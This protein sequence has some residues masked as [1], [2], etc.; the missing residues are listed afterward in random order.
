MVV[1]VNLV[2]DFVLE[3]VHVLELC[4]AV[5]QGVAVPVMT[6]FVFGGFGDLSVHLDGDG[7]CA[8][9]DPADGIPAML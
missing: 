1:S 8:S 4:P 2:V 6:N 5:V 9:S 3:R 7:F